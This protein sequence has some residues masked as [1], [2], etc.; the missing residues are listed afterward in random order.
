VSLSVNNYPWK[1][2]TY[3]Y[4]YKQQIVW[5]AQVNNLGNTLATGIK[6][7]VTI[8]N[9]FKVVSYN[10]IQPGLLE[11]DNATNTFIWTINQLEGGSNLARGSYASFSMMLESLITGSGSD[12][13]INSTIISCDQNNT[14]TT[15]TRI[16]DLSINPSAD[17]QIKQTLKGQNFNSG[18]YVEIIVRV[19]NIGPDNATNITINDLLPNGLTVDSDPNTSITY[20]TGSYNQTSGNWTINRLDSNTEA[21]L[22][23]NARVTGN[24]GD[25]IVNRAYVAGI[26]PQYDWNTENNSNEKYIKV[27]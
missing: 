24:S 15:K 13:R 18:D 23:I 7:K 2:S 5:L 26:Q 16:R 19:R 14:G 20:T 6:V 4:N 25:L 22:T 12:F 8:G 9:A 3:I 27:K 17:I 10:L 11:F 21:I 1:S